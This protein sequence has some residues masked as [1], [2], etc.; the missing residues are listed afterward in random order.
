M[1]A[2]FFVFQLFC[3]ALWFLDE[4][5]YY[6][7]FT[8]VMLFI[9]ESTVVMQRLQSLREMRSMSTRPYAIY[10]FRGGK[11]MNV[12]TDSLVPGDLVSI[13]RSKD[14]MPVP[15]DVLL[16]DG[17]AIANEAMLSGE[18]TPLLKESIALRDR[19]ERF[20]ERGTDK[21]H[22]LYGGTKILQVTPP[23]TRKDR[24]TP[25]GGALCYVLRTGFGTT[26][27]KLVRTIIHSTERVTA[28]NME[29]FVF[30]LFLLVFAVMAAG[31]VW[32]EGTKNELRKRSKIL[33]ECGGCCGRA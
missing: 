23:T 7:V 8:L 24:M 15:C 18:S 16:L 33:L 3:V 12:N 28:N 11:W 19:K 25:D 13:G 32:I 31:Y 29:A 17:S 10:A 21:L 22:M 5:W 30:I 6:S 4:M 9:F 14:E 1:V 20:D 2:P 27:G 26:Q